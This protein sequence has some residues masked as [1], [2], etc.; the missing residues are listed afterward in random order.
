[1]NSKRN[2]DPMQV[3]WGSGTVKATIERAVEKA[4]GLRALGRAL[5]WKPAALHRVIG[6]ER[7]SP[8]RAAQLADYLD[9]SAQERD[10]AIRE[11]LHAM[12]K[13]ETEAAYWA[14]LRDEA[15]LQ[16]RAKQLALQAWFAAGDRDPKLYELLERETLKALQQE[17]Q[18]TRIRRKSA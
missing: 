9:C 17:L 15:Y 8:F 16:A 13:T 12:A 14:S 4:G 5:D 3:G 7:I 1:M 10:F 18:D 2:A 6:G 11:S